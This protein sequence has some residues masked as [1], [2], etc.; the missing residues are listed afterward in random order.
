MVFIACRKAESIDTV[1]GK[2]SLAWYQSACN[3]QYLPMSGVSNAGISNDH[4]F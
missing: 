1:K 2:L 3:G 4:L